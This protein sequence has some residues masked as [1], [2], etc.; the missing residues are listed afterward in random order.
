MSTIDCA[1]ITIVV[2]LL[3]IVIQDA[4]KYNRFLSGQ[5]STDRK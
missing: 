3:I 4:V 2:L 1:V 5:N